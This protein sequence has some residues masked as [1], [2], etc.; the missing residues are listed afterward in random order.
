MRIPEGSMLTDSR[1]VLRAFCTA[2]STSSF[3][4]NVATSAAAVTDQ[5]AHASRTIARAIAGA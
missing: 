1:H 5:S 4:I 3:A 2:L